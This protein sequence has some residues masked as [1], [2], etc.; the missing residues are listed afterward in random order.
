MIAAR[1]SSPT[2]GFFCSECSRYSEYSLLPADA[3]HACS[4]CGRESENNPNPTLVAGGPIDRCPH[5][6]NLEFFL[7]KDLPQQLGCAAVTLTVALSTLAYY[8][9]GFLPSLA[10]LVVASLLDFVLYHRLGDVTICYRCHSELRGFAPNPAHGPFDMHRAE[11][12]DEGS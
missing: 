9:W 5:C 10:V 7:D 4:H 8:F 1:A 6:D 2:V 12:Y 3:V 11:E